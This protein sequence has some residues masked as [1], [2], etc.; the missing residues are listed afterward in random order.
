MELKQL[1]YFREAAR[2]E[3]LTRAAEKVFLS[4]PALS[5]SLKRLEEELGVPLFERRGKQVLLNDAGRLILDHADSV[6]SEVERLKSA[7]RSYA[8][9]RQELRVYTNIPAVFRYLLPDFSVHNPEVKVLSE[10]CNVPV[11]EPQ[12]LLEDRADIFICTNRIEHPAVEIVKLLDEQLLLCVPEGSELRKKKSLLL[13]D[14]CD[15]TILST[16]LLMDCHYACAM[17][18]CLESENIPCTFLPQP[19]ADTLRYLIE[20]TDYPTFSSAF[21]DFFH[22]FENRKAI[23]FGDD[24]LKVSYY[25]ACRRNRREPAVRFSAWSTDI[26]KA[27]VQTDI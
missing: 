9:N 20:R 16:P 7:A 13:E 3:N 1:E 21:A 23:P 19:D 12:A 11:M 14:L 2:E 5:R 15:L 18:S 25:L 24:R 27:I 8:Q 6:L 10:Y 22:K 4:Q 17:K 26:C